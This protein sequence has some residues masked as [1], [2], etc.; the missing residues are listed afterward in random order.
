MRFH[1]HQAPQNHLTLT[2]L[3]KKRER[4]GGEGLI[5][6]SDA[7]GK[8]INMLLHVTLCLCVCSVT[9]P[10]HRSFVPYSE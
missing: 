7:S 1:I 2:S 5:F 6:A 8:S 9:M 3:T 4:G 10:T